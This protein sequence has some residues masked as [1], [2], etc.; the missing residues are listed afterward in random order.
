MDYQKQTKKITFVPQDTFLINSS[1]AN[2]IIFGEKF[3][4]RKVIDTLKLV[5]L[6]DHVKNSCQNGIHEL[7]GENGVNFIRW[8]KTKNKFS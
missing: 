4:E 2:N 6:W 1:I 3:N 8:A 5:D 7:V